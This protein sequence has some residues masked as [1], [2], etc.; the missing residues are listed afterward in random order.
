MYS[1][2]VLI[3]SKRKELA[4]RYK[5]ILKLLM[6]DVTLVNNL[7]DAIGEI[8]NNEFE[9]III[10]DTIEENIKEFIKKVRILTYNFRPSIIAVSKSDELSDK[11]ELLDS[12]ADDFLS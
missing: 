7:S 3:I 6:A 12:G 8:R 10:S 11:L 9:F 2:S 4:V 1:P 5:K